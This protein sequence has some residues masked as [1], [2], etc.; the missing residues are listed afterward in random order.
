MV[1][2][3]PTP[4]LSLR[5][6]VQRHHACE[7]TATAIPAHWEP[8]CPGTHPPLAPRRLALSGALTP[9][10][11]ATAV[12]AE[13]GCLGP[14][15]L[16]LGLGNAPPL[17][18]CPLGSLRSTTLSLDTGTDARRH[19]RPAALTGRRRSPRDHDACPS[20]RAHPCSTSG[21]VYRPSPSVSRKCRWDSANLR[22]PTTESG[23]GVRAGTSTG[24]SS[25]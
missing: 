6:D 1:P 8:A 19:T 13:M 24:S 2:S 7:R 15:A 21:H 5:R 9:A 4:L 11:P 16:A 25:A 20:A 10:L 23:R 22:A 17:T 3:T 18:V 14:R 12:D